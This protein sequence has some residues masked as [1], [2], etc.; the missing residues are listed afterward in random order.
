MNA[1]TRQA[2]RSSFLA[3]LNPWRWF[4][5]LG[6]LT[7]KWDIREWVVVGF[8]LEVVLLFLY[9]GIVDLIPEEK[10][11]E[12]VDIVMSAQLDFIEY[13]EI[14][15]NVPVSD[16]QDLSD[17]IIE[18]RDL[19]TKQ[20]I[21]WENAADPVTDFNQRYVARLL[22]DV[23]DSDYPV[24]ARNA[25]LGRVVVAVSLYISAEG[26]IQDVKIRYIS[27]DGNASKPFDREFMKS[28]RNII[29]NKTRLLNPPFRTKGEAVDFVWDTTVTFTLQ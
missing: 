7:R 28:A 14:R 2:H 9:Q 8:V 11:G 21:N 16:S 25:N 27:S 5:A 19:S 23:S 29:L 6:G 26:K 3:W 22:V 12:P 18:K 20:N 17:R 24:R 15:T 13:Q 1:H 4:A 10:I